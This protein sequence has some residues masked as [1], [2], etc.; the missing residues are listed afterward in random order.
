M[1]PETPLQ[2]ISLIGQDEAYEDRMKTQ[3]AARVDF[4]RSRARRAI[5][6]ALRYKGVPTRGPYKEG[7][8]VFYWRRAKGSGTRGL[9]HKKGEWRGRAIIVS[10]QGSV[11]WVSHGGRLVKASREGLRHVVPGE[12]LPW[13]DVQRWLKRNQEELESSG[14]LRFEQADDNPEDDDAD[15]LPAEDLELVSPRSYRTAEEDEDDPDRPYGLEVIEEEADDDQQGYRAKGKVEE[16]KKLSRRQKKQK[17]FKAFLTQGQRRNEVNLADLDADMR[18]AMEKEI[19]AELKRWLDSNSATLIN[20]SER[21]EGKQTLRARL[22]LTIKEIYK[23]GLLVGK[24]AKARL[25]VLG[26]EDWRAVHE[27]LETDSPT[28]NRLAGR[29]M[30]VITLAM[31]WDTY[32]GDVSMAFLRGDDLPEPLYAQ[33]PGRHL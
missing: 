10:C 19:Q 11:I 7:D 16:K 8:Q 5:K 6:S 27:G 32:S 29:V 21:P 25:V 15:G 18:V 26:F 12:E 28:V 3:T 31:G 2:A 1:N 30:S 33:V 4:E 22:V 13:S 17:H 24:K 20:E 14:E 23:N 9:T